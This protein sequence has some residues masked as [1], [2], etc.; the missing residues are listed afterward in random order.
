MGRHHRQ[1]HHSSTVARDLG[2]EGAFKPR[3]NPDTLDKNAPK[4]KPGTKGP[5]TTGEDYFTPRTYRPG[6]IVAAQNQYYPD[7]TGEIAGSHPHPDAITTASDTL[8][9]ATSV[10][11][12]RG[13]GA[14]YNLETGVEER[15]KGDKSRKRIPYG[16]HVLPTN[17]SEELEEERKF[18]AED[19]SPS[20]FP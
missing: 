19:A 15:H 12:N 17:N 20:E 11:V 6:T 9:G 1:Q 7:A 3:P 5:E 14:P 4:S 2:N 10:D 8:T 13:E 16:F 18:V